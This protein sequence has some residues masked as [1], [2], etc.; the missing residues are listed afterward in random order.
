[1]NHNGLP[2]IVVTSNKLKIPLVEEE[3]N[4]VIKENQQLLIAF[5]EHSK[6]LELR[7]TTRIND[8]KT[9]IRLGKG[10]KKSF[11]VVEEEDIK[12]YLRKIDAGRSTK[13]VYI[14]TFRKF[15]RWLERPEVMS[16]IKIKKDE[17]NGKQ[18]S[19]MLTEEELLQLIESYRDP[20]ERALIATLADSSCRRG[21]IAGLKRSDVKVEHD[22]WTISVNGKTG[23]RDVP[24]M[25]AQ[26]YLEEWFNNWHPYK[27][28][29]D[30]PLWI[31]RSP[32]LQNKPI[33]EQAL[34]LN[35]IWRIVK[36][37]GKK[38]H[39]H[40]LRHSRLTILGAQN[41]PEFM[42]RSYAGWKP[43]STMTGKYCH[44]NPEQIR[45]KMISIANGDKPPEPVKSK[46][47]P[48]VCPRCNNENTPRAEY[49][50]QCWLPLNVE[51]AMDEMK[52]ISMLRSK[53]YQDIKKCAKEQNIS[54]NELE[55]NKLAQIFADLMEQGKQTPEERKRRLE[56]DLE[57]I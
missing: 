38:L 25:F 40:L 44:T 39:P 32:R 36:N 41:M 50:S 28:N 53:W 5:D 13:N 19:E 42:M 9:L 4:K 43:G 48:K 27:D 1:M 35:A 22:K 8:F 31:S 20:C 30:A 56:K 11:R 52:V 34:S 57:A 46:L 14:H 17:N 37:G 45:K 29:P 33:E 15:F 16:D 3:W 49:C 51:V 10:L 7:E 26:K 47:Q 23:K 18:Y 6:D 54:F 2:I 21:E 24:L 12:S 55:P